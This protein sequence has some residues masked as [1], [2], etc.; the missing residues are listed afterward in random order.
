M[1]IRRQS[2]VL[3]AFLCLVAVLTAALGRAAEA[4]PAATAGQELF[5]NGGAEQDGGWENYNC[6]TAT[7]PKINEKTAADKHSGEYSRQITIEA[8][9]QEWPGVKSAPFT[10][11]TGKTYQVRFWYKTLRG[12]FTV[13]MRNGAGNNYVNFTAAAFAPNYLALDATRR[14]LVWREFVGQYAEKSGGNGAYVCFTAVGSPAEFYVDEAS[15]V[16][17]DLSTES[18]LRSW[19]ALCPGK[20][21]VCWAKS[22]WDKL[23]RLSP[24]PAGVTV[25]GDVALALGENEYESASFV[26]TNLADQP[27]EFS[28]SAPEAGI[29]ITLRQAVWVT[30]RSGNDVNDA[31]PLLEGKL[32]IPSGESREVW[33]TL[34]SRGVKPGAYRPQVRV[35]APGLPVQAV[36]LAVQVYP[37]VLPDDKPIYTSYWDYLVPEW[38]TPEVVQ[39]LVDDMKQHYVNTPIVHPWLLRIQLDAAGKAKTDFTELDGVLRYYRQLNPRMVL[40]NLGAETYLETMP[41]FGSASWQALFGSWLSALVSH[42][43]EAGLGYDQ[44]ALYPYDERLD[45]PVYDLAKR[46][47]EIDPK[48]RVYVN[49]TGS[50]AQAAAIAPYVDIWCPFLYDYLNQGPYG[51]SDDKNLDPKLLSKEARFFWTYANPLSGLPQE[52]S[53]Y[54]DY[55]LAVWRAWQAGMSGFGY[56]IYSYKTHWNSHKNEDGENWA[57]VYL[58]NAKDAPP[59]IS[60]KEMVV[61]SKRWEATREGVEDYVYLR[62]LQDRVEKADGKASAELL[63]EGRS[64]LAGSPS[65]VL[66]DPGNP[67]LA[68]AAKERVLKVLTRMIEEPKP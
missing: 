35:E 13:M 24:P 28:V 37:V 1:D 68:G 51:P 15:V 25:G 54:A 6:G 39:A 3:G 65:A 29:P 56:W 22:P 44:F 34:C 67:H 26:V 59:G 18:V 57:V 61:P 31:L 63:I 23:P 27:A 46:I 11:A 49:H 8:G 60:T 41:G 12:A 53:A 10:T 20:A 62:L 50:R 38:T 64:I 55:R 47:K 9:S 16:E 66:A 14:E 2:S 5:A 7:L 32:S 52:S 43:R 21:Y 42:L 45:Q 4:V 48:I 17:V 30:T 19:R 40:L 36:Q 58:A 33:L